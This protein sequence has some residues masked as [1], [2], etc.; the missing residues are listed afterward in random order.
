MSFA[1]TDCSN[2]VNPVSLPAALEQQLV[3]VCCAGVEVP[4]ICWREL[5]LG[6]APAFSASLAAGMEM[7]SCCWV[8]F[9]Q[10]QRGEM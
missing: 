7:K 9:L 3:C 2:D 6:Q 1:K 4:S 5:V 10:Q 8:L